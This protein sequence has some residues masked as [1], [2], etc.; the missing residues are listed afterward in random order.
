MVPDLTSLVTAATALAVVVAFVL[1]IARFLRA[2]GFR[3]PPPDGRMLAVEEVLAL[4]TRRRLH[5]LRCGDRRVLLLTGGTGDV[6]L[7]WLP[8]PGDPP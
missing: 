5:L 7:G 8:P 2:G 6:V 1:L 4:D 3:A